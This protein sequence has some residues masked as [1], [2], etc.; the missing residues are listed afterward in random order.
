LLLLNPLKVILEAALLNVAADNSGAVT[1][2][3]CAGA[4]V[5]AEERASTPESQRVRMKKKER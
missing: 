2:R 4:T 1:D 5:A 3:A